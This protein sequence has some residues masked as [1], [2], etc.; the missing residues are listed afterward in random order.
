MH[1]GYRRY[2]IVFPDGETLGFVM[3]DIELSL[4]HDGM[5]SLFDYIKAHIR[6]HDRDPRGATLFELF[7]V[8]ESSNYVK[9]TMFT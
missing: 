9:V 2:K 7:E 5:I 4:W 6:R 8:G 3:S 1:E